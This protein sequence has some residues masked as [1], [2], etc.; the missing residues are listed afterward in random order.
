M[1]LVNYTY[2][3]ELLWL[4]NPD[5]YAEWGIHEKY[6]YII[7]LSNKSK[8]Q[9]MFDKLG[10]TREVTIKAALKETECSEMGPN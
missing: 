4:L 8:G 2:K 1:N 9:R 7:F 3:R 5:G 6:I 10:C